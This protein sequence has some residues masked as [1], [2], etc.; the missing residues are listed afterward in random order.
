MARVIGVLSG[1]G[2]VGKTVVAINLAAALAK[3]SKKTLLI[4]CNI[5]TSHIGLYLGLY[6]TPKTL[7]DVL[8]GKARME[9]A[10]YPHASGV[11]V[12]PASLKL[13]DLQNIEW[14]RVRTKLND[15]LDDYDF[16]ILDSSPGFNRE[17][18]ITLG[19]CKEAIIVT[20]PIVHTVADAIRAKQASQQLKVAPLGVVLNM[21]RKKVYELSPREVSHMTEL[22]VLCTI[23]YD[24]K[25]KESTVSK[26]PVIDMRSKVNKE[27]YKLA[28]FMTGEEIKE[29]DFFSRLADSFRFL[30]GR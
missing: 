22:D 3:L 27:F 20:D 15:V 16:I 28:G 12:I 1:K 2:G 25:V 29:Q 24:E 21:V 6:S 8:R 30:A 13:E 7:N 11:D 26:M 9:K 17:S 4:D 18:L 23:P 10:I 14:R 5:T 19:T